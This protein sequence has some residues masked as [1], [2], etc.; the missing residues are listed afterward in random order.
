MKKRRG[1][2]GMSLEKFNETGLLW[3]VNKYLR[4]FD[5]ALVLSKYP[6]DEDWRFMYPVQGDILNFIDEKDKEK[7]DESNKC[8]LEKYLN[9]KYDV[10]GKTLSLNI[11]RYIENPESIRLASFNDEELDN[12]RN[13]E[14]KPIKWYYVAELISNEGKVILQ[15]KKK[16]HKTID[17]AKSELLEQI[18]EIPVLGTILEMRG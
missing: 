6:E 16:V 13:N 2:R 1:C 15:T 5:V 9:G 7:A 4:N 11:F 17:S 10:N 14:N 3:A 12:Y 8:K 18:L